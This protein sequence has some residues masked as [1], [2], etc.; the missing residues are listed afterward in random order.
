MI[1]KYVSQIIYPGLAGTA[2][3]KC[4]AL[5]KSVWLNMNV[6]SKCHPNKDFLPV[7]SLHSKFHST[8]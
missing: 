4:A 1:F 7:F 6:I 2:L 5:S 8:T 3:V